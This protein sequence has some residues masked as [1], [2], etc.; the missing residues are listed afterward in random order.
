MCTGCASTHRCTKST[1]DGRVMDWIDEA[2]TMAEALRDLRN[3]RHEAADAAKRLSSLARHVEAAMVVSHGLLMNHSAQGMD[4]RPLTV[5]REEHAVLINAMEQA[6]IALSASRSG[7]REERPVAQ[8]APRTQARGQGPRPPEERRPPGQRPRDLLKAFDRRTAELRGGN[9]GSAA[10]RPRPMM[11]R[12]LPAPP[13]PPPP[14]GSAGG[15]RAASHGT[16]GRAG[17]GRDR[18]RTR[19]ARRAARAVDAPVGHHRRT[20]KA[21]ERDVEKFLR[22]LPPPPPRKRSKRMAP[23][24]IAIP[25]G[26]L[27]ASAV[28]CGCAAMGVGNGKFTFSG[29]QRGKPVPLLAI[30]ARRAFETA[31]AHDRACRQQCVTGLST[32]LSNINRG[33]GGDAGWGRDHQYGTYPLGHVLAPHVSEHVQNGSVE[34]RTRQLL[35]CAMVNLRQQIANTERVYFGKEGAAVRSD[36]S[37]EF[38]ILLYTM[39]NQLSPAPPPP[40]PPAVGAAASSAAAGGGA[41]RPGAGRVRAR[42]YNAGFS[43]GGGAST[44]NAALGQGGSLRSMGRGRGATLPAWMS[45]E[46]GWLRQPAGGRGMGATR[47]AWMTAPAGSV[48]S[49]SARATVAAATAEGVATTSGAAAKARGTTTVHATR[50]AGTGEASEGTTTA[51]A[52]REA[53]TGAAS[54]VKRK[55]KKK[56]GIGARQRQNKKRDKYAERRLRTGLLAGTFRG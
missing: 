33:E 56:K 34:P 13:P 51:H 7:Q 31:F 10:S 45:G 8:A 23:S 38:H 5:R 24:C 39:A 30:R 50:E 42:M 18:A 3:I 11:A 29:L 27:A 17:V 36:W 15:S 43:D 2:G 46:G 48:A 32:I 22:S 49:G 47:P 28:Y 19:P 20:D 16:A 35:H 6:Q 21:A 37:F 4:D 54:G 25:A 55:K 41:A 53:G 26:S 9:T 40:P 1:R 14:A 44:R 12:P 52:A